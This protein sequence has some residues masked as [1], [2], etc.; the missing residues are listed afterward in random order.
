MSKKVTEQE[1]EEA[2]ESLYEAKDQLAE[3]VKTLSK[4]AIDLDDEHA[5]SYLVAH[6]RCL[7]DRNHGYLSRDFTVQDWIEELEAGEEE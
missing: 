7:V 2:I 3:A 6:L 1:R 4:V 5:R